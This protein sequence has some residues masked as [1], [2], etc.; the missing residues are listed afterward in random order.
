MATFTNAATLS[1]NGNTLVSN[2]VTG[3]L[4]ELLTVSKTA[5]GGTYSPNGE[6][7]FAVSLVNSG[8][9]AL[10]GLTLND[11]LGAYAYNTSTL[12]PLTYID[13]SIQY[14]INGVLQAAPTATAGPPLVISGINVPAGGNALLVYKAKVNEYAPPAQGSTITNTASVTG[15]GISTAVTD[16]AVIT[17]QAAPELRIIKSLS[18]TTVS[19]NGELTY[20]FTI[21]NIGSGAAD[22]SAGIVLADTF[23]PILNPIAVTFNSA[24]WATPANYTYNSSTGAFSTVA[25]QITVPA[26]TY[27]Q[28]ASG[29]WTLTPGSSTL[30]VTGTV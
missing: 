8:A 3:T 5:V 1:Y 10:T 21:E 11:N 20:T 19:D 4:Q 30:V 6:A 2:T 24:A 16:Q 23:N 26:A 13:G 22:A 29:K 27:T 9:A 18:P 25:G 7:V 12:Y 28:D 15:A 14:Y 17:A